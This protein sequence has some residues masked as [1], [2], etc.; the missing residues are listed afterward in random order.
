MPDYVIFIKSSDLFDKETETEKLYFK[1]LDKTN[2]KYFVYYQHDEELWVKVLEQIIT[3]IIKEY[4]IAISS[5]WIAHNL[6]TKGD[7]E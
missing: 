7:R 5:N 1:S 2:T 4:S 6:L 3:L